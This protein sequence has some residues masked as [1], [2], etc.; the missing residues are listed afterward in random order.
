MSQK[1]NL[2]SD[3]PLAWL[4]LTH[5]KTRFL[6]ASLGIASAITLIFI[7][8]GLMGSLDESNTV[9]HRHLRGDLVM[10]NTQTEAVVL[11]RNFSRRRLYSVLGSEAVQDV[12]PIY[13]GQ[14]NF[15]NLKQDNSV[16][17]S[18][19][20][21]S[22]FGIN[23][24][25]SPFDFPSLNRQ[26]EKITAPNVVLFDQ[27][28]R[29]EYGTIKE[30]FEAGRS[31]RVELNGEQV[32]IG[33]II[34]FSGTSFGTSGNLVTSDVNFLNFFPERNTEQIGL[35]L[36]TLKSGYDP[37]QVA[38]ALQSRLPLDVKVLTMEQF[39]ELEQRYWRETTIVGFI[40]QMG[41]TVGFLI[42]MY[43]VYQILYADISDHISDYAILR[44]KGYQNKYFW[45]VLTQE[46]V[47]LSI[48]SYIPGYLFSLALYKI[49]VAGTRLP[50]SMTFSRALLV[51]LLTFLMCIVAGFFVIRKLKDSDPADLF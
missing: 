9:L 16:R 39:I 23:P 5:R 4:Q 17:G 20:T 51:L 46:A 15:K 1:P 32:T 14:R 8:L 11:L 35:G 12:Q 22:V 48:S 3:L 41:A 19:R 36:I 50:V 34:D 26:L 13:Y 40:F 31:I 28:S 7:Q 42:G 37:T 2:L 43:I 45:S 38:Q 10:L 29:S 44:A 49:V 33:G 30:D 27:R 21:I 25:R 47:I 18:T 24:R 6:T